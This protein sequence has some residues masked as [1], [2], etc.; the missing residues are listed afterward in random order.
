MHS[1][2]LRPLVHLATLLGAAT[3]SAQP[4]NTAM[5]PVPSS[6]ANPP[7]SCSIAE[8]SACGLPS[9]AVIDLSKTKVQRT[10]AEWRKRLTPAQYR[11]ARQQGTEP[12]FENAYWDFHGDGVFVCVGC[13]TPLFDAKHKFNSGTGWPSYWQPIEPA[14][15]AETTDRS[16]GM[17]RTE[18][19]CAVCGSHLGHLFDDGPAPT[20]KRYCINSASL[21]L[22]SRSEYAHWVAQHSDPANS[23]AK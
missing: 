20:G 16:H 1:I 10:D 4:E 15:V 3:L 13:D 18:V 5:K 7:A 9:H 19:H 21:K 22:L 8:R 12:A 17:V 2:G 11:V 6:A 23:P 14:F